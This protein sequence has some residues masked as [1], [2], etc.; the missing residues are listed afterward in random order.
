MLDSNAVE[1]RQE[2]PIIR[3]GKGKIV[4]VEVTISHK[5]GNIHSCAQPDSRQSKAVF[6]NFY[7]LSGTKTVYHVSG[8]SCSDR[9]ISF[10]N[11]S[12][13]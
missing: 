13:I 12:E 10:K 3:N 8:S 11:Q 2:V 5:M 4:K 7:L 9:D 1:N 6:S